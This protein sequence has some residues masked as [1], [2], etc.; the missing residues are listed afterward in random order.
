MNKN[1]ES[2]TDDDSDDITLICRLNNIDGSVIDVG[3]ELKLAHSVVFIVAN[4]GFSNPV[5]CLLD[6]LYASLVYAKYPKNKDKFRGLDLL[7]TEK[8]SLNHSYITLGLYVPYIHELNVATTISVHP[9]LLEKDKE[10]PQ[11]IG[12]FINEYELSISNKMKNYFIGCFNSKVVNSEHNGLSYL[13]SKE[14]YNVSNSFK[15]ITTEG[16]YSCYYFT[17]NTFEVFSHIH[18]QLSLSISA[19]S[20]Y[21]GVQLHYNKDTDYFYF[22]DNSN[23]YKINEIPE[24][25]FSVF[26][27]ISRIFNEIFEHHNLQDIIN[28]YLASNLSYEEISKILW[29]NHLHLTNG[30]ILIKGI[31]KNLSIVAQKKILPILKELFPSIKWIVSVDSLVPLGSIKA[32]TLQYTT[33]SDGN[34]YWTNY[35]SFFG[36]TYSDIAHTLE[37]PDRDEEIQDKLNI[38]LSQISESKIKEA[39]STICDI[40]TA[41]GNYENKTLSLYESRL[42]AKRRL[43]SKKKLSSKDS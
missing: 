37:K 40:K 33:T 17:E 39:D 4:T 13:V 28:K 1:H 6:R 19:I 12:N 34:G 9:E 23:L 2:A 42:E 11:S 21:E 29:N 31:N 43:N 15:S 27:L 8:F 7:G 32:S 35:G 10:A 3:T 5:E 20:G 18:Q 26:F 24:D 38:L 25:L 16:L 30:F 41:I 14:N 22:T 36:Q